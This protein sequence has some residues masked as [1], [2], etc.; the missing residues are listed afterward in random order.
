MSKSKTTRPTRRTKPAAALRQKVDAQVTKAV[1]AK[2][3]LPPHYTLWTCSG[4]EYTTD[5]KG[6]EKRKFLCDAARGT[7]L[8]NSGV[9]CGHS[10]DTTNIMAG[11]RVCPECGRPITV[12]REP[13]LDGP[14]LP[15]IVDPLA[16]DDALDL[17]DALHKLGMDCILAPSLRGGWRGRQ[18]RDQTKFYA[19]LDILNE[20]AAADGFVPCPEDRAPRHARENYEEELAREKAGRRRA[21]MADRSTRADLR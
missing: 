15:G 13:F 7:W 4:V 18:L 5:S 2:R 1:P 14:K 8:A 9:C 19:A 16:H 21:S 10:V 3:K 11:E 17:A 20:A 6:R 12:W